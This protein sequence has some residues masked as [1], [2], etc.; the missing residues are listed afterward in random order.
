[1]SNLYISLS[2]HAVQIPLYTLQILHIRHRTLTFVNYQ[3]VIKVNSERNEYY[4]HR[5]DYHGAGSGGGEGVVPEFDPA[6]N[7]Y[8]YEEK[9]QS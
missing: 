7:S 6:K 1:M 5:N 3:R 4:E 2:H 8:F 9:E